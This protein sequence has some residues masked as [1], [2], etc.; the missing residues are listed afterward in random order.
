MPATE[1]PSSRMMV[2]VPTIRMSLSSSVMR[3]STSCRQQPQRTS[4]TAPESQPVRW[5]PLTVCKDQQSRS[6]LG[7]DGGF[8]KQSFPH[9]EHLDD[10]LGEAHDIHG[11]SHSI[12]EGKDETDGASKLWP[13]APGDEIVR[14]TWKAMYGNVCDMQVKCPVVD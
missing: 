14:P 12:G 3:A 6:R 10:R 8:F 7:T 5:K 4:K 1:I 11:H 9:V 2:R 13:Q